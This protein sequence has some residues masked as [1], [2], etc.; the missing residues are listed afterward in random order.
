MEDDLGEFQ[1]V[2]SFDIV[3]PAGQTSGT[4]TVR[5]WPVKDDV[6]EEDETV[7]LQGSEVVAGDSADSLPV[8]SAS[9]TI[10][11]DDTR[12]ITLSP[13]KLAAGTGISMVGRWDVN[14]FP[15]P[16]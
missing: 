6:D 16:G 10:I 3:I 13:A 5:F 2:E 8:R 9:F 15:G 1:V 7:T 11:D 14:V 4:A 12:G